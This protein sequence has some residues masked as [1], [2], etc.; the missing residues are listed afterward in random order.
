[1]AHQ[2][3]GS[4]INIK[5]EIDESLPQINVDHGQIQQAIIALASNAIDAMPNG[6]TLTFRAKPSNN[7][8]IIEIQD[9]GVGIAP[10]NLSKVFEPFFTT[11][12]VGKG[13]GLGL[14]VCYGIITEHGGRLAVRSNLGIGTTFTIFLPIQ[15]NW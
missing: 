10:E 12:E 3:R 14:A 7:R 1:V 15:K 5:F 8:V 6:G 9:S 11:K 4:D 2:K 13:T